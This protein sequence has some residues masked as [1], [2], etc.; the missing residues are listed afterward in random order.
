[1]KIIPNESDIYGPGDTYFGNPSMFP[2]HW[3]EYNN[4]E[5][6]NLVVKCEPPIYRYRMITWPNGI[7]K[8]C[9]A[10]KLANKFYKLLKN[11]PGFEQ[12]Y[13][14]KNENDIIQV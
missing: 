8:E 10:N 13:I 7:Y 5:I 12:K 3:I 4:L 2:G 14:L 1:M 6:F 9:D 11:H